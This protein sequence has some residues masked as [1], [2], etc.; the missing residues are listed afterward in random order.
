MTEDRALII[1]S[2][3]NFF[4]IEE[5]AC[6]HSIRKFG[7]KTWNFFQLPILAN[8]LVI[9]RDIIKK[10]MYCNGNGLT[11]RGLRC[12]LCELVKSAKDV[13]LTQHGMGNAF[14]LTSPDYTAEQMRQM[15]AANA[16]KLPFPM[17]M[18]ADVNWLHIDCLPH[19]GN[20]K[21][22]IFKA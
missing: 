14:D 15:I 5:L 10:P 4:S 8:L 18:E 16:D 3:K 22:Y 13:Y 19:P 17:R 21:V 1:A 12:N 20:S 11:Q 2:L 9:R 6:P 7:D